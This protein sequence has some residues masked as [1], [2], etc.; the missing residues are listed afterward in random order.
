MSQATFSDLARQVKELQI[1]IYKELD[2]LYREISRVLVLAIERI[3]KEVEE[4]LENIQLARNLIEAEEMQE[5]RPQYCYN[6]GSPN[7]KYSDC[8]FSLKKFC[9][10]CGRPDVISLNCPNCVPNRSRFQN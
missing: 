3:D 6:C 9:R 7:H 1:N 5:S 2:E 4:I 10:V 8:P